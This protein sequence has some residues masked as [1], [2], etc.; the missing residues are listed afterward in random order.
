MLALQAFVPGVSVE[1]HLRKNFRSGLVKPED[2][3]QCSLLRSN[4][5]QGCRWGG[6]PGVDDFLL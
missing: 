3:K 6:C 2:K 4:H 1:L 5:E